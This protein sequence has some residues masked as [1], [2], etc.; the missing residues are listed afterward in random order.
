M[1]LKGGIS[2]ELKN[3]DS[4]AKTEQQFG[5]FPM[6]S[7]LSNLAKTTTCMRKL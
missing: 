4:I 6:R 1:L 2:W 3:R 5:V 7:N